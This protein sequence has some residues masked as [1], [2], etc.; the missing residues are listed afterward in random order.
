MKD[1]EAICY[2]NFCIQEPYYP[3]EEVAVD[4]IFVKFKECVAFI[5]YIPK[6]CKQW[7]IKL[8]KTLD[9]ND[10]HLILEYILTIIKR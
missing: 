8:Y 1:D 4:E 3:I 6:R 9:K 5:H 2:F 7:G 10:S